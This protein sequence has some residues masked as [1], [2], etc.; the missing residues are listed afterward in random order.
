MSGTNARNKVAG[1]LMRKNLLV[2]QEEQI[3]IFIW[4]WP[5]GPSN[6]QTQFEQLEK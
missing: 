5:D 1:W 2:Q 3:G 6:I 4:C